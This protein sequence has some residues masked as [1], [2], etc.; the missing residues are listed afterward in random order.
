[1][2]RTSIKRGSGRRAEIFID[3][4]NEHVRTDGLQKGDSGGPAFKYRTAYG[5]LTSLKPRGNQGDY[6][7]CVAYIAGAVEA[8]KR[9][10]IDIL[11]K[12]GPQADPDQRKCRP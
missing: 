4:C 10:C 1:V 8:E 9:L 2:N 7:G 6:N 3:N 5:V 11:P 12:D